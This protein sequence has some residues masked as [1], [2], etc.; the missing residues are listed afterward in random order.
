MKLLANMH[1]LQLEEMYGEMS[2][3]VDL[4]HEEAYRMIAVLKKL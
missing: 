1:G 2:L 3:G 4:S